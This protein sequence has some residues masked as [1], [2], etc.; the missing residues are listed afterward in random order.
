MWPVTVDKTARNGP[1]RG[2]ARGP[3]WRQSSHGLFVPSY[4]NAEVV[5]Q[6]IVEQAARLPSGGAVTGWAALRMAGGK[7]FD[8]L[9]PD[10]RT[11]LPVPLL[12]SPRNALRPATGAIVRRV[13]LEPTD[14]IEL[15]GV[16]CVHP[17]RAT[18]DEM[19]AATDL[20]GCVAIGDKACSAG[21]TS[22]D[23]LRIHLG[24]RRGTR[25]LSLVHRA[26]PLV[27]DRVRSPMESLLRLIWVEVAGL[28]TPLCNWPVLNAHGFKVAAVDVLGVDL[29]IYAEFDGRDH[30]TIAQQ[31]EDARRDTALADLGLEGCRIVGRDIFN[32][33]L[34]VARIASA[35][36]RAAQSNRPQL[37]RAGTHP[38]PLV[39]RSTEPR[40]LD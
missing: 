14:L 5:E 4:V 19:A 37:W 39:S 34:V 9:G 22:V 25:G 40:W 35:A 16:A 27:S 18:F 10:G 29:G 21:L 17:T 31:A 24:Q 11:H 32:H 28:S 15:Q 6:R 1:T 23:R 36:K 30:R 13:K 26:L 33:D 8:G 2:S 12:I 38:R 3:G 20:F 7:Q